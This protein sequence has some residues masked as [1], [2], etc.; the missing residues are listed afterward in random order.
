MN[1]IRI[2]VIGGGHLGRIHTRLASNLDGCQLV[3]VADTCADTRQKIED[4]F[5][6][7]TTDDYHSLLDQVDAVIIATPTA[8]HYSIA[9]ETLGRGIHTLIEKPVTNT[10]PQAD[11]LI[12]LADQKELVLQVGHVERFNPAFQ[13]ARSLNPKPRYLEAKRMSGYTFRSTDVGVVMDLMIHD[14]DLIASLINSP[15]VE[16][17]AVG[18]TVFGPHEDIAQARLEFADGTVANLTA[19]RCSFQPERTIQWFSENGFVSADMGAGTVESV[20]MSDFFGE[21]AETSNIIRRDVNELSDTQLR[22]VREGLFDDVLPRQKVEVTPHNAIEQEQLDFVSAILKSAAPQVTGRHGRR[23]VSI[24]QD[25]L[26]SIEHHR[27]KN[28]LG[29]LAGAQVLP[30]NLLPVEQDI[31]KAG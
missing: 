1:P 29:Q 20:Q 3:G 30:L 31:R 15:V 10:T 11:H 8:S 5:S 14:I 7:A 27:W 24:A 9:L 19:S 22:Q 6:V 4:E 12:S 26:N 25:I 13:K 18:V 17:R 28:G 21:A 2:A 16:T 23:A